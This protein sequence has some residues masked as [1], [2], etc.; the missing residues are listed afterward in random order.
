MAQTP[1]TIRRRRVRSQWTGN[2]GGGR[3]AGL[4][5]A[6]TQT[7]IST[8]GISLARAGLDLA[9]AHLGGL[10]SRDVVVL[11]TG[12]TGRV[13]AMTQIAEARANTAVYVPPIFRSR[14]FREATECLV[15]FYQGALPALPRYA[16]RASGEVFL[17]AAEFA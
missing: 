14:P 10:G 8:E 9:A 13:V 15:G 16:H 1:A 12:S 2:P 5:R 3:P 17:G 6:R 7:A 11:G 4:T